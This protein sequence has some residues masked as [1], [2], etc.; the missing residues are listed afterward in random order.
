MKYHCKKQESNKSLCGLVTDT[1]LNMG[2]Q[3]R[4]VFEPLQQKNAVQ[5]MLQG[6]K[7]P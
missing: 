2:F 4:R 6:Y 3:L 1:P 7:P 5:N